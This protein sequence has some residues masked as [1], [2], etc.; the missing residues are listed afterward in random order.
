MTVRSILKAPAKRNRAS[1]LVFLSFFF[2]SFLLSDTNSLSMQ[3]IIQHDPQWKTASSPIYRSTRSITRPGPYYHNEILSTCQGAAKVPNK[4]IAK[5][6]I[7]GFLGVALATNGLSVRA[8][9]KKNL[10]F[11]CCC[12]LLETCGFVT[13]AAI[14]W[15]VLLYCLILSRV[16]QS[17]GELFL[18]T[19]C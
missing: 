4:C 13:S 12:F 7:C 8:L 19:E 11:V 16:A 2:F 18:A 15:A 6:S 9:F 5:L 17:R 3:F 14:Y 10:R 1:P